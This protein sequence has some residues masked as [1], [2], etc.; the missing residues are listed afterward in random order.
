MRI[1]ILGCGNWGSVFSIIQCQ[2]GHQ[3]KIWEFDRERSECVQATRDNHPYLT[4]YPLPPGI[5]VHWDVKKALEEAECVV[6]AVPSQTLASVVDIVAHVKPGCSC[7]LN[8][9]KGIDQQTLK[10]PSEI[11]QQGLGEHNAVYT[12]SGPCIANEIVRGEPT[13]AVIV[14][15][16]EQG[17]AQLQQALTTET[18]RIYQ[19]D[20]VIGVELGGATK[21]V[22]AL[23]CGIS[24]GLGYGTNV[25]GALITRGIVEIQRL[26]VRM[27]ACAETFWGLSGLGDLVT[28]SFSSESRN[29]RCGV[30]IGQGEP[31]E[32]IQREMVMVAEGVPTAR[33]IKKLASRYGIDMPICASVYAIVYEKK[34]PKQAIQELMS[35]P[36]RHE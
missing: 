7:Y 16:D 2:N 6:F 10:R 9:V 19:G 13:A 27:G 4:G 34:S 31:L 15:S 8:L 35:R 25:K 24:D 21:N 28:T 23:G 17:A 26:G 29:H 30:C 33:A 20:D 22:I 36:L 5:A 18:F 32:Q 11:I 1:S 3:V 14:G 12:L